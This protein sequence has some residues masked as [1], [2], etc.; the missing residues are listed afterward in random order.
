MT[1]EE[2][3]LRV[4]EELTWDPRVEA[5]AITVTVYAGVVTLAGAVSSTRQKQEAKRAAERVRG[6][7]LVDDEL[8]VRVPP[9][10]HRE[11]AEL[12]RD[13]LAALALD[14]QVPAT[15]D[16]LVDDGF[17][18]LVGSARWQHER[19]EARLVAA[20]VRGV[21]GVEDAIEPADSGPTDSGPAALGLRESIQEALRR[22]ARLEADNI[23]VEIVDGTATLTGDVRSV[24]ERDSV[25]AAVWAAPGVR[26]VNDRLDIFY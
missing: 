18:T 21:S 10:H 7:V 23:S 1:D 9:A 22:L 11:D 8:D 16:A 13:V 2:L 3:K 6:V 20:S 4:T 17:V 14:G 24:W 5:E 25:I 12:R 19:A 26:M 15:I